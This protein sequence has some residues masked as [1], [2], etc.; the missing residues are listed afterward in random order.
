MHVCDLRVWRAEGFFHLLGKCPILHCV[1]RAPEQK[2][3]YRSG[4][5]RRH[6]GKGPT[7]SQMIFHKEA[8]QCKLL[9]I[10]G[11]NCLPHSSYV[12]VLSPS[13]QRPY[14]EA[15]SL[16]MIKLWWS[17][18]NGPLTNMTVEKPETRTHREG[19]SNEDEGRDW[20][21]CIYK[22]RNTRDC[23]QSTRSWGKARADSPSQ[24]QREPTLPTPRTVRQ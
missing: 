2:P 7:I 18:E 20:Q 24:P 6:R 22:L 1:P 14:L 21:R 3:R 12:E 19:M 15:G 10:F 16:L 8:K 13:P 4:T 23:Q 11:L 9:Y 5:A 17:H